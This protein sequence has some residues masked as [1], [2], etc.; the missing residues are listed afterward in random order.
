M[1][2]AGLRL[3]DRRGPP[4]STAPPARLAVALLE[5]VE[6]GFP[7]EETLAILCSTYVDA[8]AIVSN[9]LARA[10]REVGVRELDPRAAGGGIDR[11]DGARRLRDGAAIAEQ[12]RASLAPIASLPQE[13]IIADHA[14][15]LRRA[16]D[17]MGVGRRSRSFDAALAS[18]GSA[19]DARIERALARDQAAARG[20]E[21][22]LDG[23]PAAARAARVA[24]T[25]IPRQTFARI[26]GD[27]MG[28][29]VLRQIGARGGAV[30]LIHLEDLASRRADHV[31]VPRLVDGETPA[32]M[33]DDG[34][35]GERERRELDQALGRRLFWSAPGDGAVAER[36][37][38]E[39]LM[40]VNAI[41]AARESVTL[42]WCVT[43]DGRQIGRSTFVE[44]VLRAAPWLRVEAL[45]LSPVPPLDRAAAPIDLVARVCLETHADPAGRL[46]VGDDPGADAPRAAAARET[47]ARI[48]PARLAR[49]ETLAAVER[50]RWRFFSG[51]EP[52]NGHVGLI[53]AE[54]ARARI[55][56]SAGAPLY[57]TQLERFANCPF[58][59]F[60]GKVLGVE[61]EEEGAD[62]PS[63]RSLGVVAHR[64]L[65]TFYR[66]RAASDRLPLRADAGD[67]SA[68]ET[69]CVQVFGESD[70]EGT[71]GHP[72]L[73]SIEQQRLRAQLWRWIVAEVNGAGTG[74]PT[75]FEL[76][77]GGEG[78]A[79]PPLA[80]GE[81]DDA[82]HVGGR[83]DRIDRLPGGGL[84]VLDYKIGAVSTQSG[85][86]AA[87]AIGTTALQLPIYVA[88]ARAGLR[89]RGLADDRT[90]IDAAFVSL[91]DAKMTASLRKRLGAEAAE[92]EQRVTEKVREVAGR[93]RAGAFHVSPVDCKLCSYRS[94]CRV[95][96]LREE[97]DR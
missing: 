18:G 7:R 83:I 40:L 44:E 92:L 81:G 35:F 29:I 6:R 19:T 48:W 86:L 5:V 61:Q 62:A 69:A 23:L 12:L 27:L 30:R 79:L 68:L 13:A 46:P 25:A 8:G 54:I 59:F 63:R 80:C 45:P 20:V 42:T 39:S 97:E 43:A 31:I 57:A 89:A 60:A 4:L 10:A 9:R 38:F 67:R 17:A 34:V 72:E 93:M 37:P 85:R 14:A 16:W 88:A 75:W 91:R 3:D 96:A 95:V 52:A 94:V 1:A 22:L 87:E 90:V 58:T 66:E 64:V 50:S 74:V 73:W 55:G 78:G 53:D 11:I 47:I 28:Q 32:R 77:F 71:A 51:L 56:G 70:R 82:V 2:R 15:A 76:S 21:E 84:L 33:L 36:T 49:I 41:A 26:L 24:D 65:E